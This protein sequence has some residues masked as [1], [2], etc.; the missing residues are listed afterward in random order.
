MPAPLKF[1]T[2]GYKGVDTY[3]KCRVQ[4]PP[5]TDIV[6][7]ATASIAYTVK[8]SVGPQATVQTGSGSP[9]VVSSVFNTLQLSTDW[10]QDNTGYNFSVLV[11][12]SAF[13]DAGDYVV[14]FLITPTGGGTAYPVIF[15]HHADSIS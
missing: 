4:N 11:P 6:Q 5:G 10:T 1:R 3:F 14:T 7:S 15:F 8:E 12:G 9:S 13:P 2:T